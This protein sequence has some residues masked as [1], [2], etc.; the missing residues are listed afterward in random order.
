MATITRTIRPSGGD[1]TS[2]SAWEAGRQGDLVSAENIE[3][4]ECYSM[5]DTPAVNVEGWTT[6]ATCYIEIKGASSDKTSSNTGAWSTGRYRLIVN[7]EKPL[8]INESY[9]YVDGLQVCLNVTTTITAAEAINFSDSAASTNITISRCI[10]RLTNTGAVSYVWGIYDN[11]GAGHIVYNTTM[12]GF[13]GGMSSAGIVTAAASSNMASYNNTIAGCGRG[14]YV[15]SGTFIAVNTLLSSCTAPGVGTFAAG[16]DYNVTDS[17]SIGYTVTGGGNSHD[18]VSHTFTFVN[19]GSGDYHLASN[20]AGAI[21]FGVSDPGSGL[22]SDDIDGQ[23]RSGS[24]DIGA[25][26]YTASGVS[27][28]GAVQAQSATSSGTGTVLVKG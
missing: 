18:H 14:L 8:R 20:D 2:L 21:G 11:G 22:F 9:V 16:T 25:D 7:N 28:S 13:V 5:E 3:V 24:W 4:A 19:A 10:L 6:S 12:Y 23:T 27:G 1:Y 15:A 26:E 17:A